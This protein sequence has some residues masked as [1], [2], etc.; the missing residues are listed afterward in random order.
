M[1]YRTEVFSTDRA[2]A[3]SEVRTKKTDVRYFTVQTE[4]ERAINCLLYGYSIF[5]V[6]GAIL[7]L[8]IVHK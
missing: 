7:H 1:K 6:A 3:A 5:Q 4:Q 2:S 8:Y